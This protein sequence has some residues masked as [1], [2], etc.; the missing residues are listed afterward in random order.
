[1]TNISELYNNIKTFILQSFESKR[2][3][4]INLPNKTESLFDVSSG[5]LFVSSHIVTD[6]SDWSGTQPILNLYK[7][8]TTLLSNYFYKKSEKPEKYGEWMTSIYENGIW[9]L[10]VKTIEQEII[11]V[12]KTV[13]KMGSPYIIGFTITLN[14]VNNQQEFNIDLGSISNVTID[15]DNNQIYFTCAFGGIY[16]NNLIFTL[17]KYYDE[18]NNKLYKG[19][20]GEINNDN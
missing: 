5:K 1:M 16:T 8:L 11:N 4:D 14:K 20:S 13:I 7:N 2:E 17:K 10:G 9:Y 19:C 12:E 3:E 18:E 15:E 6:F